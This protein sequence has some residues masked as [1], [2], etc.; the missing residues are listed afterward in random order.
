MS[1]SLF[2]YISCHLSILSLLCRSVTLTVSPRLCHSLFAFLC[3][4][5]S[6]S[7]S[8]CLPLYISLY[9]CTVSLSLYY[10]FYPA[11]KCVCLSVSLS[12]YLCVCLSVSLLFVCVSVSLFVSVCLSLPMSLY[13][14]FILSACRSGVFYLFHQ[15]RNHLYHYKP[16]Y[17]VNIVYPCLAIDNGYLDTILTSSLRLMVFTFV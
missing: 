7:V 11:C 12:A 3:V 17:L 10:P 15:D 8:H 16:H 6:L 1:V 4:C 9:L 13:Y 2:L 14:H 5:V